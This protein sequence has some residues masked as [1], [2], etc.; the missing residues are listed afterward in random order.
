MDLPETDQKIPRRAFFTTTIKAITGIFGL[1]LGI[2]LVGFFISPVLKKEEHAWIDV[3][4]YSALKEGEP[5]K[6]TYM[7]ERK[8]GWMTSEMRKTVFV[9]KQPGGDVTVW[10]NKC[11]HLGCAVDFS[12]SSNQFTCPCHGGIFDVQGNVVEGPP[13]KPL[14]RL[15]AKVEDNRVF[16]KEA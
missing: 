9:M 11:T 14:T 5:A 6:V 1:G 10:S 16:I 15:E 8:D 13:P 2:P 7:Y 12:T 4:D 3:T